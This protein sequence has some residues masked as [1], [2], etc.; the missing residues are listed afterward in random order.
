MSVFQKFIIENDPEDGMYMVLAKCTFHKQLAH[1][2]E[3]V[4]GGGSWEKF[5]NEITLFGQ[6]HDFGPCT[7]DDIKY[8]IENKKVFPHAYSDRNLSDKFTFIWQE[9][10]GDQ[11]NLK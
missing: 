5:E 10:N 11:I 4:L 6:S 1:N 9:P 3:N 8:V 7:L 2:T